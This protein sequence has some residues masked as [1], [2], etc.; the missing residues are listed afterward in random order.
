MVP[1][2]KHYNVQYWLGKTELSYVQ[3]GEQSPYPIMALLKSPGLFLILIAHKI[4]SFL[5]S[6]EA[7]KQGRES[8]VEVRPPIT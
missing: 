5:F 4:A 6:S 1:E 7:K 3:Q 2:S 8:I